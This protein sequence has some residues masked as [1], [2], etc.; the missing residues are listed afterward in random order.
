MEHFNIEGRDLEYEIRGAGK[1]LVFL[2]GMGGSVEQIYGLYKAIP[3]ISL[4]AVNQQG[5]GNSDAC[6]ESY[7]FEHLA[8]DISALLDHPHIERAVL[9]GISMGAAVALN[10]AVRFPERVEKLLLI[11][12]AWTDQPMS[13][14]VRLAYHDLGEALRE[15]GDAK[16][17]QMRGWDLVK[18]PS[19]YT[20]NAF[21]SAFDDAGC[22]KYWQ[23]YLILPG[24]TP[25]GE[26]RELEKLTMP[27]W[28]LACR[29]DLCHPFHYGIY[30]AEYIKGA[31]FREIVDKDTD[32]VRHTE[33]INEAIRE[34]LQ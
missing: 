18:E 5:H 7:D 4:I 10:L 24:K 15:G 9:A 8:D 21:L 11:R 33:M 6:W 19:A 27:V 12:N 23:K 20:R 22:L 1:P 16:F 30:L 32:S 3:G 2:H 14:E 25:I 34:I 28:I 29:N 31:Q 17:K 13:E 26:V